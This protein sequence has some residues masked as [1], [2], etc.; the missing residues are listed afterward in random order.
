[1]VTRTQYTDKFT[2]DFDQ[3]YYY[4]AQKATLLNIKKKHKEEK[5]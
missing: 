5:C 1:M 4:N 3:Q 2:Y